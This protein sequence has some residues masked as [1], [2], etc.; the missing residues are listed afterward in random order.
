MNV[1]IKEVLVSTDIVI[2][3]LDYL[4]KR[5]GEIR[6]KSK[7][8]SHLRIEAIGLN[9]APRGELILLHEII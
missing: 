9:E 5:S 6:I 7:R 1:R 2:Q 4:S 8:S 3:C